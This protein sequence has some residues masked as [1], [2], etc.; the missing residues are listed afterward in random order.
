MYV[1]KTV[2]DNH[3]VF[4]AEQK[5]FLCYATWLE[6]SIDTGVHLHCTFAT[7]LKMSGRHIV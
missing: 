2:S 5:C 3:T 6:D 1:D 4:L 7:T